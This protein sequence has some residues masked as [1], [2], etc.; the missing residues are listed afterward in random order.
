MARALTRAGYRVLEAPNGDEALGIFDQQAD[1]IDLLVIDMR[2]PLVGGQVLIDR[3]REQRSTVKV[4]AISGY[5]PSAPPDGSAFLAKPFS[6][7]DL[8]NTIRAVLDGRQ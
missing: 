2:L 4:V 3:L 5:P 7:A 8:L 6:N 1:A